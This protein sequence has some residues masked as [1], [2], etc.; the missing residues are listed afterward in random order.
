MREEGN[1]YEKKSF[2]DTSFESVEHKEIFDQGQARGKNDSRLPF[3]ETF[4]TTLESEN[5]TSTP[6]LKER[7]NGGRQSNLHKDD[8]CMHFKP[9]K[10]LSRPQCA[11]NLCA[12]CRK[13][14]SK[15][16]FFIIHQKLHTNELTC[17]LC[18][19]SLSSVREVSDHCDTHRL[20][21]D[22]LPM[23]LVSP[24]AFQGLEDEM[25]PSPQ[26]SLFPG[27]SRFQLNEDITKLYERCMSLEPNSGDILIKRER[28]FRCELCDIWFTSKIRHNLHRSLHISSLKNKQMIY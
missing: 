27:I 19:I 2:V 16:S 3:D 28:I 26:Q 25:I 4:E 21:R 8:D 20:V 14:F 13:T 7:T 12:F 11:E 6:V 24:S 18:L 22:D 23:E 9:E 17:P 10:G 1:E 5:E 15:L